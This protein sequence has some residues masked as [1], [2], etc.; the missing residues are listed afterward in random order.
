MLAAAILPLP[1]TESLHVRQTSRLQPLYDTL[2]QSQTTSTPDGTV[3]YSR[4]TIQLAQSQTASMSTI[5]VGSN[6]H[7]IHVAQSRTV[8]TSPEPD[9]S[10]SHHQISAR[11]LGYNHH[12]I[13][14]AQSQ[15]AST[16]SEPDGYILYTMQL[17]QSHT[18]R[19]QLDHQ[20]TT[21]IRY[22][23]LNVRQPASYDTRGST[24][25]SLHHT[26]HA[27]Q[28]QI[29]STSDEPV[30]YSFYT[31]QLAQCQ[32]ASYRLDQQLQPSYDTRGSTSDRQHIRRTIWLQF[33]YD[34]LGSKSD[35]HRARPFGCNLCIVPSAC[36]PKTPE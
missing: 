10:K 25:D 35:C 14:M 33:V 6:H 3:S 31:I 11:P 18:T 9:G 16:S 22:T 17:A 19:Y 23:W 34:S 7:T 21:T 15:I 4:Y 32:T 5:P 36:S 27:A 8:S 20:V 30:G 2:A 13:H 26:T 12:T 24:S 1:K 28:R 29:A